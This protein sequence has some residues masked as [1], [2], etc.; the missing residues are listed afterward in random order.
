MLHLVGLYREG[1]ASCYNVKWGVKYKEITYI[2]RCLNNLPP[3]L[4]WAVLQLHLC[5][6]LRGSLVQL[7]HFIAYC[8][9]YLLQSFGMAKRNELSLGQKNKVLESLQTR[10][11]I[12]VASEFEISQSAFSWIT[13][14]EIDVRRWKQMPDR[15]RN[16][17]LRYRDT[18]NMALVRY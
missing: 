14:R 2:V 13:S 5:V 1:N 10:N 6:N 11:Q 17:R 7:C 4:A 8:S 16:C 18:L 9:E 15:K 3:P 12:Q